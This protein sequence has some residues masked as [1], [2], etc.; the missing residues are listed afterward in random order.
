[1]KP[2]AVFAAA[3]TAA[4]ALAACS[5]AHTPSA[6]HTSHTTVTHPAVVVNC[7]RE[8]TAWKQGPAGKLTGTL[9]AVATASSA[10][11]MPAL[12]AALKEAGPAVLRA[13]RYP[14]PACADPKGYW[15]ALM[16]HV[17]SAAGSAKPTSV[18]LALKGV[19]KLE[20]ELRT[21]LRTTV[22]ASI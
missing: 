16:M 2:I 4:I 5:Q 6:A 20:R 17:N 15:M 19:P 1:M 18:K 13:A 11:N 3:T 12:N 8:Y 14:I 21:E 10:S 7:P 9:N 22:G